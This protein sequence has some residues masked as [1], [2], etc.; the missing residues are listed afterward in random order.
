MADVETRLETLENTVDG[1]KN[2]VS[3]L[4]RA[5]FGEATEDGDVTDGLVRIVRDLRNDARLARR[6]LYVIVVILFANAGLAQHVE[7]AKLFM[8]LVTGKAP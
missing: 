8:A 2:D 5:V 1:V 6:A 7:I 4:S 3:K